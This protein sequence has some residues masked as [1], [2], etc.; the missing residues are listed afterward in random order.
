MTIEE[1]RSELPHGYSA[2]YELGMHEIMLKHF[3]SHNVKFEIKEMLN[4]TWVVWEMG[5]EENVANAKSEAE[6]EF[7]LLFSTREKCC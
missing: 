2:S 3:K 4:K 5:Q 7:L 1:I 6:K